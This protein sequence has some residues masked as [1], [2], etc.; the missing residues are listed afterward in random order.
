MPAS[1]GLVLEYVICSYVFVFYW[2]KRLQ[3]GVCAADLT[4]L[5]LSG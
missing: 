4:S 3:Y 5:W 2:R 1:A